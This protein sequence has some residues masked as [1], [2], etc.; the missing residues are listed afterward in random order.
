VG[1]RPLASWDCG[2]E[3]RRRARMFVSCECC[4]LTGRSLCVGLIT[5]TEEFYRVCCVWVWSWSHDNE[6]L[7][8]Y[9]LLRHKKK[10]FREKR[11]LQSTCLRNILCFLWFS[12]PYL[13]LCYIAV[14]PETPSRINIIITKV[15]EHKARLLILN[16]YCPRLLYSDKYFVND[17]QDSRRNACSLQVQP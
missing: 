10:W 8:H 12:F 4:V 5:R 9:G 6:A 11:K 15:L 1:L 3:S 7:A 13:Q 17:A 16:N 2:F 14:C